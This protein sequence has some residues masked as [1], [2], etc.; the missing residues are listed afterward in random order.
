[1]ARGARPT[2]GAGRAL[3]RATLGTTPETLAVVS[4]VEANLAQ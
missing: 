3:V 2:G 4:G 1:V